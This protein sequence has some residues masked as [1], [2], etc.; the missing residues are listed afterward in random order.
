MSCPDCFKGAVHNGKPTG[1]VARLHG[2]NVYVAE[3]ASGRPPKGI[4]VIIPD[5]FGWDFVNLRLMADN[6]ALKND[7]RVYLPDFMNGNSAPLYMIDSMKA[8]TSQA[9]SWSDTFSKPYHLFWVLYGFVTWLLP[10]RFGKSFPIV[11]A[12]FEAL[13][14]DEAV[15]LPVG[16]AG[17]CW[18]GKHVVLLAEGYEADG[19]PL[20]DVA[21]TAHPSWLS[22]YDEIE[23]VRVPISFAVGSADNQMSPEQAEET[24]KIVEAKSDGQKG[25]VKIYEGYGHGFACRVDAKNSDPKGAEQAEDQAMAWFD[26]HFANIAY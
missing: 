26:K 25:E 23:K 7:Y 24:R 17:Y 1:S 10:N 3:P 22:F 11:K 15:H 16:A 5:A 9:K 6:F 2:L 20:V 4:V 18:G 14:Q 13:R 21:F 12:F 8:V 19:K